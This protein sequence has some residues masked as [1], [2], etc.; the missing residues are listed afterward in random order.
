L[1]DAARIP[2]KLTIDVPEVSEKTAGRL[3]ERLGSP[4]EVHLEAVQ[5]ELDLTSVTVKGAAA[6][7]AKKNQHKKRAEGKKRSTLKTV[8]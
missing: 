1:N 3:V 5:E 6:A 8:K 2:V 4:M 7:S